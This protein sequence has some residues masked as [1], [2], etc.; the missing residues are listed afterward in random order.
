MTRCPSP[1]RDPVGDARE[2]PA[3]QA[4]SRRHFLRAGAATVG[5]LALLPGW[6]QGGAAPLAP[7]GKKVL[8][9][10]GHSH[11]DAAWLW[12]WRDGADAALNTFRSALD[13]INET[14]DFRFSHSSSAHYRWVQRADP[15]MFE[16]LRRRIGEGRWEVV[17]GWP[18]EPDCNLP[19]TESFVR[20]ALYGK[21]FCRQAL[22][23]DVK[24]GFNPDSFGHAAGL[25]T[26]LKHTGYDYYVFMRPVD[27]P[28]L[29]LLFWWEG[30]DGSRV[31]ALRIHRNYCAPASFIPRFAGEFFAPGCDHGAFF[32][33]V[34]NHGGAV[35]REQIAQVLA[36]RSEA[37]LPELRWSTVR[38]FFQAIERSPAIANLPVI[39]DELQYVAR[40]C[41]SSHGE[42]KALNRRAERTLGG[43]ETVSAVARLTAGHPYPTHEYSEAW[44]KIAFNQFHDML[45]GTAFL[46]VYQD[47][48]DSVGAACDTATTA[49]VEALQRLARRVDTRAMKEGA[50]FLFNALPWRRTALVE[51][52][53]EYD[54]EKKNDRITHLKTQSGERLPLQWV[55]DLQPRAPMAT[56]TAMVELPPCGYKVLELAHGAA[57]PASGF[58]DV[59]TVSSDRFGLS[60]LRAAD[61]TELL[62]APIGLVVIRDPSSAFGHGVSEF[63]LSRFREELGR[64][65]FVSSV[66]VDEGPVIKITRQRARWQSSEIVMDIVEYAGTDAV[67]LRFAID[68]AERGQMLKLEIPVGLAQPKNFAK[69]P[70]AVMQR[71]GDGTEQPYQD[72]VAVQGNAK[73][74][75]CTLGLLNNSTYSY[76]CLDGLLRTVLIRSAPFVNATSVNGK[77]AGTLPP[78][79]NVAW[80]DQGRQERRFWL[81]AGRGTW[82]DLNLDRRAEEFQAP[83]EYVSDSAHVGSEPWENSCLEVSPSTVAVLAV[84]KA[85]TG[86]DTILRIQERSGVANE[87]RISSAL[88]GME[89]RVKL[90]PFEIKTLRLKQ[91]PG[92][93][94]VVFPISALE[95]G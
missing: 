29:P 66:V 87:A 40:G 19:S 15:G 68:W 50:V 44:W 82:S 75:A 55:N 25:P 52:Q 77:L 67:E 83:A 42:A 38:E 21:A 18:V 79:S 70:A 64:P 92:G 86:D 73:G 5:S 8:H 56:L 43:A 32:L 90:L 53:A 10:I 69:V 88:L 36:L 27:K 93:K 85:E 12:P 81:V 24:I 49:K 35:T 13:R 74:G 33:G 57:P 45:A 94:T 76:D 39:R 14:P 20:H 46:S 11:I 61:G 84:K 9:I 62:A 78:N 41:Y 80:M 89:Q 26:I 30:P 71:A 47:V 37:G 34:G 95:S 60:S 72:W 22:G 59:C 51:F 4:L 7:G 65:T 31:L 17:G 63:Y 6:A 16:E 2:N 23:V 58:H 1:S 3:A 48:R 91:L 28:N 54:P